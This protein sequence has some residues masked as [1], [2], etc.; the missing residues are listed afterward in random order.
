MDKNCTSAGGAGARKG[1]TL[2][3]WNP[4]M[5]MW[6]VQGFGLLLGGWHSTVPAKALGFEAA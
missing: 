6:E 5:Q 1:E 4:V 3:V 2:V